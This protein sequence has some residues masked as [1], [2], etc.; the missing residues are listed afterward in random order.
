MKYS[1]GQLWLD[2]NLW[3]VTLRKNTETLERKE[4]IWSCNTEVRSIQVSV[5]VVWVWVGVGVREK[6]MRSPWCGI[7]RALGGLTSCTGNG[8][9]SSDSGRDGGLLSA[10]PRPGHPLPILTVGMCVSAV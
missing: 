1:S 9:R 6:G 4:G 2:L 8:R 5:M 3:E 10:H 7:Q